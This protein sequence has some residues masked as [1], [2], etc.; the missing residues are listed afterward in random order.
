MKFTWGHGIA[1]FL[2]VFVVS[3]V[4]IVYLAFQQDNS[5]VESEYYPKGLEYQKQIDRINN[6][7]EL[8]EKIKV[9]ISNDRIIIRYPGT[10]VEKNPSGTIYFYRPSDNAG[11]LTVPMHI[12]TSYN[13]AVESDKLMVGK[14]IVKL[15]WS[16]EG[17]EFYQEEVIHV[18]K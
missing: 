9:D 15:K 16:M 1:V 7:N 13:Q 3:M 11:D 14:Y 5:L 12:D 6:T 2:I 4:V 18:G 17:K 10:I 8:S